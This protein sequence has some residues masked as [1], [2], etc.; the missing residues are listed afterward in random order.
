MYEKPGLKSIQEP[1]WYLRRF[2]M[3]AAY[4]IHFLLEAGDGNLD[5]TPVM[6]RRSETEKY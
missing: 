1:F 2:C 4:L 6:A 5:T 3:A